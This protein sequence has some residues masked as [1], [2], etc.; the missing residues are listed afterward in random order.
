MEKKTVPLKQLQRA[1]RKNKHGVH[2]AVNDVANQM[3]SDPNILDRA[4]EGKGAH[5][6]LESL[7]ESPFYLHYFH[8]FRGFKL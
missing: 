6:E 1:Y 4:T 8:I 5:D 2:Q 7:S 3:A